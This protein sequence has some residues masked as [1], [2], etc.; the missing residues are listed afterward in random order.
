VIV[1][2]RYL[3]SGGQPPEEFERQLRGIAAENAA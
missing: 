3:I 2:D 1:N